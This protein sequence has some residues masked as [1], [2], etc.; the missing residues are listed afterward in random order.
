MRHKITNQ[1]AHDS[2]VA[3]DRSAMTAHSPPGG[4][5]DISHKLGICYGSMALFLSILQNV[6]LLYHVETFVSIY[7]IDK[8]SFWIGET[9]FL[10]WN[11]LNDPLFGWVS[12]RKYLTRSA[13]VVDVVLQ[14]LRALSTHGPLLG[15][16]F[17]LIWVSWGHP[18]IQ[19]VVCLCL[20]DGF[21]TMIDLHHSALMAD[22][23]V[24]AE[25]RT[26]LNWYS[27]V[28][29]A[30][31]SLSVFVSYKVWDRDNM[32]VFQ[33]FCFILSAI[34]VTGFV[35]ATRMLRNI[36]TRKVKSDDSPPPSPRSVTYTFT[37]PLF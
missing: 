6:F 33:V 17:L 25:T 22:M 3:I 2:S 29:N 16:T 30:L 19:F 34:S 36:Y 32:L 12:D 28:F 10:I 24:S 23:A 35:V 18:A 26:Y 4:G 11:S 37:F 15:V 1:N 31:G 27:S 21:L 13:S 5:A 14:R 20:Y 8:M 7:K 9:V